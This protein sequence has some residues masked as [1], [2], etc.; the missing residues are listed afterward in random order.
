MKNTMVK[1]KSTVSCAFQLSISLEYIVVLLQLFVPKRLKSFFKKS[2][3]ICKP[4]YIHSGFQQYF[5][6]SRVETVLP[7]SAFPFLRKA[8]SSPQLCCLSLSGCE[9]DWGLMSSFSTAAEGSLRTETRKEGRKR[10]GRA[11][12]VTV[13]AGKA[14]LERGAER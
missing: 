8:P 6:T 10:K 1:T 12:G 13:R 7:C 9:P 11:S 4:V 3:S 14:A 2:V 5:P